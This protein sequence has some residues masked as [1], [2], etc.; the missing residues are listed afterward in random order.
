MKWTLHTSDCLEKLREMRDGEFDAVLCDPPYGLKFMGKAW[1]HGVPSVEVWSEVQRVLKPGAH[2]LAFGG[3]RTFHRL[4]CAIED[5]GFEVRDC[6]MWLYGSGFPKS[7]DISKALDKEAGAQ[8]EV[9]GMDL[10]RAARLGNQV[11]AE[12]DGR[13]GR[14]PR[15]IMIT[16]PVTDAAKTWNGYGTALK[17]AWEPCIVAMKP[18]DGTFANN[19]LRHGVA[20]INVEAG[21][22]ESGSDYHTLQV[23]QGGDHFSIGS[24]EKTRGTTFAPAA[25]RWPANLILDAEAAESLDAQTGT[26][27]SG[28][29]PSH[30]VN[31]T[32]LNAYG[33]GWAKGDETGRIWGGDSGGA[34]RFF[35][36]A[37]ASRRERDAGLDGFEAKTPRGIDGG[38]NAVGGGRGSLSGPQ[39]N[40]HPC[41]KPLDLNRYLAS[42]ILPPKR[43]TPR[44][45]LVPFSGS[46][47]EMIGCL[48]SGWDEVVGIEKEQEYCD[49]A[50]ARLNHWCKNEKGLFENGW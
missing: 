17:P 31:R 26:L 47:S 13:V 14:G 25:G 21:R 5:A 18:L 1:D 40:H 20:G 6:L 39:R 29:L 44:R 42:L 45:I 36:C 32:S 38:D 8:R 46:G 23:I 27:K 12:A 16:A 19:A 41:L 7:M 43:D 24:G 22:V 2:L 28:L 4:T 10:A 35:Y 9:L 50:N 34:S 30:Q 49:I 48:L 37:K 15:D 33:G 11:D 3:T